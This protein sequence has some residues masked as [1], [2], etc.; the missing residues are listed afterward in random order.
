MSYPRE[1]ASQGGVGLRG[2]READEVP[3]VTSG[4]TEEGWGQG[5]RTVGE[6]L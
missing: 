6:P 5:D 1:R 3:S 2:G 4:R